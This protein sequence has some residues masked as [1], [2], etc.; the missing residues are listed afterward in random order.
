[1]SGITY[2]AYIFPEASKNRALLAE[3]GLL[4]DLVPYLEEEQLFKSVTTAYTTNDG[5]IA[6]PFF[7]RMS[8]LITTQHTLPSTTRLTYDVMRGIAAEL[9]AGETL[10]VSDVYENLKTTGQYNF[11][12]AANGTCTFDS[13][14]FETFLDF[15]IDVKAGVYTDTSLEMIH[16]Y[17]CDADGY[18]YELQ[19]HEFVLMSLDALAYMKQNRVKF[20]EFSFTS[21]HSL[22]AM[23]LNFAGTQIN[24]CGYPS[25]EGTTVVLSSDA[26]YSIA[27]TAAS[28]DGAA[29][30]LQYLLSDEIQTSKKVSFFGLPVTRSAMEAVFPLGRIYYYP[31]V[32]GKRRVL[33]EWLANYPEAVQLGYLYNLENP[34]AYDDYL[35]VFTS[36]MT[37][38]DD[39]DRF[40]RFLDRATVKTAADTTLAAIIDEEISFAEGGARSAAETGKILQSRVSIYLNE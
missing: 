23:L 13:P 32:G 10:F 30:F 12:D 37:T 22:S 5:L 28:P 33:E 31:G 15:L 39:R 9:D 17:N 18:E 7:I 21:V 1:M 2:D 29:V 3:K 27:T 40:F 8:T 25:D 20:T 6:L 26:L 38:E 16:D 14:E 11:L 4:S 36:V 34:D 35:G 19:D 24:Y